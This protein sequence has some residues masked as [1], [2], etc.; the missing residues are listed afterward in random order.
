MFAT[1]RLSDR[2][3]GVARLQQLDR[4]LP[5][6]L[7]PVRIF[8]LLYLFSA[9]ICLSFGLLYGFRAT[10]AQLDQDEQ[11]YLG[12]ALAIAKG[13]PILSAR[14]T[15]G[16]PFAIA[17]I[18][19]ITSNLWLV[20]SVLSMIFALSAPL[21]Q[22]V[23]RRLTG[24]RV[25][26]LVSGLAFAV[27][28][29]AIFYGTSLYSESVALPVVLLALYCL[30][31]GFQPP[32]RGWVLNAIVTGL[33]LGIATHVR[34]M[35]LLFLPFL[36]LIILIETGRVMAA[37]RIAIV[38]LLAYAAVILPWS[39]YVSTT[40][41][42]PI[43]V[44]SNGGETLAG[45][46]TPA[47]LNHNSTMKLGSGRVT[48][49]GPGKWLA[50]SDTGYLTE[51]ENR[52]PYD[53]QDPLL[54]ARAIEWIKAHPDQAAYLELCKLSY[55][56][57]IYPIEANGPAQLLFGNI[58][59]V[60]LLVVGLAAFALRPDLRVRLARLWMPVLFVSCVALISWGSWRFRQTADAG[61]IAFC[62]VVFLQSVPI[63]D[64]WARIT[65]PRRPHP[66]GN[67][68]SGAK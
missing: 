16:F 50:M 15:L 29:T 60:V 13:D 34:P 22:M 24:S 42:R 31:I 3:P 32:A 14:R 64:W 9:A 12:M 4:L 25:A 63:A 68:T 39:I 52:L 37:A 41:H 1:R 48:W 61:L 56:W 49:V 67:A 66:A 21:L 11:E 35:Y 55:M 17:G 30:P 65:S 19:A 57:G 27:W 8:F 18:R 5:S 6:W 51:A 47:L 7:T 40:F 10:P 28:P 36:C 53:Q 54:R 62:V 44:S 23:V 45:G 20:Q 2:D 58:P 46:L 38:V 26:G 59:I 33:L 43:L